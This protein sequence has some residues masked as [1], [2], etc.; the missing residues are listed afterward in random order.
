MDQW[1][2]GSSSNQ[3]GQSVSYNSLDDSCDGSYN[4]FSVDFGLDFPLSLVKK[5]KLKNKYCSYIVGLRHDAVIINLFVLFSQWMG[6][7]S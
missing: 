4:S 2:A 5:T 7:R 3:R 6:Q 1:L